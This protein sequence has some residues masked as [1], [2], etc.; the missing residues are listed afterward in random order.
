MSRQSYTQ[1]GL[2]V[3]YIAAWS[4]EVMLSPPVV[5][6]MGVGGEGVGYLD[7]L[8]QD[9]DEG[10]LW[11]RQA[12]ARGKGGANFAAVHALRQRQAMR[13]LLCQVCGTSLLSGGQDRQLYVLRDVGH[14]VTEGE[15]TTAPPVCESCALVAARD[16]PRLRAGYIAAWV[17]EPIPWGVSGVLYHPDALRPI[18]V[19]GTEPTI[20]LAF[21]DP[22]ARW[23]IATRRVDSLHNVTPVALDDLPSQ[24]P[25]ARQ[26]ADQEVSHA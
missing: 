4:R 19:P 25:S 1:R 10:V 22:R 5:R 2:T 12:I 11:V 24:R 8:P 20:Q 13:H 15:K 6:R 23:I 21:D 14:P 16:C 9:R 17:E 18:T 3:P 7:E 26:H